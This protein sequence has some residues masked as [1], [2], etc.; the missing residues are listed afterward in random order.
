M[1]LSEP[2]VAA[3]YCFTQHII[4]SKDLVS[5]WSARR[6]VW[7]LMLGEL[8]EHSIPITWDW[9]GDMENSVCTFQIEF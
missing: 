4:D 5:H 9:L 7:E 1:M 6:N 3:H 2:F 8:A